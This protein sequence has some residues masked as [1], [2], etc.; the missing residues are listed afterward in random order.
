MCRGASM[1]PDDVAYYRRRASDER[2]RAREASRA[3]VAA[4]H[5]ELA[6]QYEALIEHKELRIV[7]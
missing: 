4:I 6:R 3:N 1:S 2:K 5:E 7:A